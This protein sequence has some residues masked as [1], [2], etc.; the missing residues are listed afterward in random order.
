MYLAKRSGHA[1]GLNGLGTTFELM[2]NRSTGAIANAIL[3]G[4]GYLYQRRGVNGVFAIL[5][6]LIL[7]F[8]TYISGALLFVPILLLGSLYFGID[9][10]RLTPATHSEQA[11]KTKAGDG[12]TCTNCG[13]QLPRKGKFCPECGTA[14]E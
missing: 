1:A 8:Y 2:A 5:A 12:R 7:Y 14:R 11:Y 6:H 10:Y 4:S 13:A 9:G 3:W